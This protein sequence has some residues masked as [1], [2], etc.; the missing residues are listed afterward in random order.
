MTQVI[1]VYYNMPQFKGRISPYNQINPYLNAA[2]WN[3]CVTIDRYR[4]EIKK[5]I[6]LISMLTQKSVG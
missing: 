1:L 5:K 2:V 6:D 3:A 4:S